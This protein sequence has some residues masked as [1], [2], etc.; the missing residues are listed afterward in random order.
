MNLTKTQRDFLVGKLGATPRKKKLFQIKN[1]QEKKADTYLELEKK[2]LEAVGELEKVLGPS[3]LIATFEQKLSAIQQRVS[4]LTDTD[5]E[6]V[7]FG[8]NRDLEDIGARARAD[9]EAAKKYAAAAKAASAELAKVAS[10]LMKIDK[11]SIQTDLIDAAADKAK[12]GD[13]AAAMN[14]LGQV[15]GA[16]ATGKALTA[17]G[18]IGD[19]WGEEFR[20]LKEHPQRAAFK[21]E[22]ARLQKTLDSAKKC[23]E[24]GLAS[25][26]NTTFSTL[27][28]AAKNEFEHAEKHGEY[29]KQRDTVI[30]PMVAQL[31]EAAPKTSNQA[32]TT[33]TGAIL[34]LLA[35]AD[36][37]AGQR[38]YEAANAILEQVKKDCAAAKQIKEQHADCA[39]ELAAAAEMTAALAVPG[40][41]TK[42][43]TAAIGAKLAK[44]KTV[45][46]RRDFMASQAL[47]AQVKLDCEFASKLAAANEQDVKAKEAAV[48]DLKAAD[49]PATIKTSLEKV[50]ALFAKLK[51]R[52]GKEGIAKKLGEIGKRLKAADAALKP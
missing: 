25:L 40:R 4:K 12:S 15:K 3:K 35:K 13:F 30:K 39:S 38:L 47:L 45:A 29:L 28:W 24:N 18:G 41:L 36:K 34:A 51:K 43:E 21:D 23:H 22:I 7:L 46:A 9:G 31:S 19:W 11:S 10:E 32:I 49:S 2:A 27:H 6:A 1:E 8:A 16:C 20:K 14:L 37:K 44:A 48:A 5:D 33:E 52:A 42:E 50:Q 26:A 17:K